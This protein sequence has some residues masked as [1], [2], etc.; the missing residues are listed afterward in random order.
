MRAVLK[1]NLSVITVKL[2]LDC[3]FCSAGTENAAHEHAGQEWR[4]RGELKK[5]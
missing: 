5:T 1:M 3:G 2:R 4:W